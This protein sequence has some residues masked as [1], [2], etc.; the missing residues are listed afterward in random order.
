MATKFKSVS[1]D[2][3]RRDVYAE[4]TAKIIAELEAGIAPWVRPWNK[5]NRPA[6]VALPYSV[7]TGRPYSGINVLLLWGAG[8]AGGYGSS[9]WL[10]F[11]AALDLGGHV[12]KGEKGTMIVYASRFTPAAERSKPLD[13]QRSAMMLKSY[14]VFNVEQCEGLPADLYVSAEPISAEH[15]IEHAEALI[16]RTGADFRIGGDQ[17]YY[18]PALDFIQVPPQPAF[19]EPINYYRT[20]FHELGHWTGHASR[21]DRRI[22]NATGSKD[23]AREEL[24]AEM[25]A[26]F[27]CATLGIE[28]TVC[29]A[30]YI[31]GW[32]AVLK[33]DNRAIFRAASLASKAA[34]FILGEAEIVELHPEP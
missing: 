14:T 2:K 11:K 34:S 19:K 5:G 29:H 21:L 16:K 22:M 23:Y 28:P 24:V 31:G 7:A 10:T 18:V 13:E 20:C 30:D 17:A 27:V 25:S 8:I 3:P 33:E 4:V 32:L 26:A 1:P 12:R 9:G 15:Q 6:S